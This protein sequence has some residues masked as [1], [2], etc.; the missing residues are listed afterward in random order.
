MIL[1]YIGMPVRPTNITR[2]QTI[3]STIA[4][5]VTLSWNMPTIGR[6]DMYHVNV[7]Y[8]PNITMNYSTNTPAITV[9]GI[10]YNQQVIVSITSVNCYSDSERAYFNITI[11]ETTI[12][13]FN[14]Y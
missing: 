7:S 2:V 14:K 4:S 10:P 1:L 13:K 6:V 8:E 9:E 5:N 11:S 12:T 3:Y